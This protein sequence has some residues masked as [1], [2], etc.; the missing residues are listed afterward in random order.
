MEALVNLYRI[1]HFG[2]PVQARPE[3]G[4][5][6]P[7]HADMLRYDLAFANPAQVDQVIFPIFSSRKR[8][9]TTERI[10]V[11]RWLSWSMKTMWEGDGKTFVQG[12]ENWF[13]YRHTNVPGELVRQTLGEYLAANPELKI[14]GWR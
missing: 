4:E 13:T 3:L 1:T 11:A 10:T 2:K 7:P 14:A 6:E 12:L 9:R 8:G 5:V